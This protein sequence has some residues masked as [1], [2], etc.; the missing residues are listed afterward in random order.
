M[1]DEH[2][3]IQSVRDNS[4]SREYFRKI[5]E[6]VQN[7]RKY[8]SI[9]SRVTPEVLQVIYEQAD[10][11][12]NKMF[13]RLASEMEDR[14]PH[15]Y[16][17]LQSLKMALMGLAAAVPAVSDSARD[18]EIAEAVEENVVRTPEF[19][20]M[21][22]A[23]LDAIAKGYSVHEILWNKTVSWRGKLLRAPSGYRFIPP[24]FLKHSYDK[25]YEMQ[26]HVD[27]ESYDLDPAKFIVHTHAIKGDRFFAGGVAR[28]VMASYVAKSYLIRDVLGFLEVHGMPLRIVRVPTNAG[29]ALKAEAMT[30]AETM[31]SNFAAVL[32]ENVNLELHFANSSSGQ[33][34]YDV[35]TYFDKQISKAVVHQ[36]MTTDD[37]SSLAQ[38][39][40]HLKNFQELVHGHGRSLA[41]TIRRDLIRPFVA[42]NYGIDAP[43]PGFVL[44]MPQ[45]RD[46]AVVVDLLRSLIPFGLRV[47]ASEVRD[48]VGFS[49]PA[50]DSE[51]LQKAPD[52]ISPLAFGSAAVAVPA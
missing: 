18:V 30:M 11:Y 2:V 19:E 17:V 10:S 34:F 35:I 33:L 42:V 46:I 5:L 21:C 47:E 36:T 32:E 26:I 48:L 22:Y 24:E 8:T 15:Y 39:E 40:V 23:A 4:L 12:D 31:G 38:A 51:V 37:G 44:N 43:V 14:D 28:N 49:A 25:P 9:A 1:A 13:L 52:S 50:R 45:K 41:A 29:D 20:K 6:S 27:Q 7:V 3:T 16:A